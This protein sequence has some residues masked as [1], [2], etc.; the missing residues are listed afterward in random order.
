MNIGDVRSRTHEGQGNDVGSR[1]QSPAQIINVFFRH[2]WD[3]HRDAREIDALVV[4]DATSLDHPGLDA[5]ADNGDDFQGYTAIV[6]EDGVPCG[7]I[8]G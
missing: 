6:D 1:A 2:G 3:T 4:R 8:T 7:Y 5:R